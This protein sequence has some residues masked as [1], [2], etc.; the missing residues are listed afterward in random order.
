MDREYAFYSMLNGLSTSSRVNSLE[1]STLRRFL[2]TLDWE[3]DAVFLWL[4]TLI[5][6]CIQKV[7]PSQTSAIFS[8][9][10]DALQVFIERDQELAPDVKRKEWKKELDVKKNGGH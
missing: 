10:P 8:L 9:D 7:G 6:K 3:E 4:R 2:A 5:R 1:E